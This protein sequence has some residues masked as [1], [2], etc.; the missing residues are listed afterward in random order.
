[1]SRYRKT[2]AAVLGVL[3]TALVLSEGGFTTPEIG[4]LVV[5]LAAAFGVY[6]APNTVPTVFGGERKQL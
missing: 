2:I 6:V 5:E 4:A 1:M 3:L